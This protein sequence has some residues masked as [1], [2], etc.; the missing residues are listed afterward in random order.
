MLLAGVTE[1]GE[2]DAVTPFGRPAALSVTARVKLFVLPTVI[3]LLAPPGRGP[4]D[5]GRPTPRSGA[6]PSPQLL[7]RAAPSTEPSA[8][9]PVV[10]GAAR[11]AR[12]A[13]DAVVAAGHVVE[14]RGAG[15]AVDWAVAIW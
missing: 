11:E 9:G 5:A 15:P 1:A 3:A 7:T 13:G 12:H 10:T 4:R 8:V 2:N 14:D 6:S